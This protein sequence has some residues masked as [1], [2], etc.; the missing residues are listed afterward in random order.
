MKRHT[1][2]AAVLLLFTATAMAD[3]KLV[4]PDQVEVGQTFEVSVEG[5]ALDLSIF[6]DGNAPPQVEWK[7]VPGNGSIRARMEVIIVMDETTHKPKWVVSPYATVALTEPGKVGIVLMVVRGGVGTLLV[8]E[9]TVGPFPDPVPPPPP[10]PPDDELYGIVIIEETSQR[11]PELAAV[12]TN[13]AISSF[14]EKSGL[15]WFIRDQHIVDE[16]GKSPVE[17]ALYIEAAKKLGM[18]C[19]FVMGKNSTTFYEGKVPKTPTAFIEL[20]KQ[21]AK[22]DDK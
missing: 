14:F 1:I 9:V 10:P 7:I 13:P 8:H 22:G 2:A 11:T 20:G 19:L 6:A 21:Y 12:L 5:L 17:F 4:G 15:T 16:N 18:P 3:M